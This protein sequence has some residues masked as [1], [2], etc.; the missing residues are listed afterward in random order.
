MVDV[1]H[2]Q[3]LFQIKIYFLNI[4]EE[5]I[6]ILALGSMDVADSY[7]SCG[8]YTYNSCRTEIIRG[9]YLKT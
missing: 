6:G 1:V 4:F 8:N 2:C 5:D 9:S 3:I 7:I